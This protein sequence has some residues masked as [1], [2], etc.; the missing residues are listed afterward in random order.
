MGFG[1]TGGLLHIVTL[2]REWLI[3]RGLVS[4]KETLIR[5]HVLTVFTMSSS[6]FHISIS[7][8][9]VII[10]EEIYRL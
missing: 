8:G 5:Y 4:S 3:C 7:S 10:F 6:M 9:I 2:E 1:L